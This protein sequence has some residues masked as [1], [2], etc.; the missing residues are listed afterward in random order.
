MKLALSAVAVA[1]ALAIALFAIAA[2]VCGGGARRSVSQ[3]HT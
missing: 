2:W 1:A 3:S